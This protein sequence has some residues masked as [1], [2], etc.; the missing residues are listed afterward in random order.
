MLIVILYVIALVF[1]ALAGLG[2]PPH[3]RIQW[4]GW[5]LFFWLLAIT[6]AHIHGLKI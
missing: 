1:F 3:P 4:L 2:V 5:G 6:I